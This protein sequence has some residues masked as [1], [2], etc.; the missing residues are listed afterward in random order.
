MV[1]WITAAGLAAVAAALLLAALLRGA[2][3]DGDPGGG[4]PGSRGRDEGAPTPGAAPPPAPEQGSAASDL[5]IYRDQLAEIDRDRARG[6]LTEAEAER[7]RIEVSRRLLDA[8]RAAATRTP[9]A[10]APRWLTRVAA[11]AVVCVVLGGTLALYGVLGRPGYGDQPLALRY[12]RAAAAR[13]ARPTQA[14]A[15]AQASALPS[16]EAPAP[17][18]AF[19]DLMTKLRATLK[20]RPD[21]LQGTML[22]ARN[23]AALGNMTAAIEAQRHV[24]D[25]RAEDVTA[26]DYAALADYLVY[27]AG[28]VV[29][30]EAEA[31]VTQ[32]LRLDPGEARALYYLGLMHA[33]TGRPDLA[34]RLWRGLLEAGP[35]DAPWIAPIRARIGPL[36]RL[37][38]V[39]YIAPDPAAGG[40]SMADINAAQD[41]TG[42]ERDEMIRGMVSGLAARLAEDGGPAT[43]W[44]RLIAAYGVLGETVSARAVWDEAQGVFAA[45]PAALAALRSAAER[46][47]VAG[48]PAPSG[49]S[50]T[51]GEAA[52]TSDRASD[53]DRPARADPGTQKAPALFGARVQDAAPDANAAADAGEP[54]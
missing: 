27:A 39:D 25:L 45:D 34:F 52:E 42:E 22:L 7:T 28:G 11:A 29:T 4:D 38:G 10:R 49:G 8:D 35:E 43:D 16:P 40:P 9:D 36:A 2:D 5:R 33:Q 41:L 13:E 24:I 48:A 51:A 32:A 44:A 26:G 3:G 21:D 18:P 1:F 6:V 17:D 30:P 20:D 31:A 37:A 23:E 19:L 50:A 53:S 47:G 54:E 12:D 46:A 15:E 14:E